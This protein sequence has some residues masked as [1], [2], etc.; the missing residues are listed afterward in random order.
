MR[1]GAVSALAIDAVVVVVFAA[2]G[3]A[4]HGEDLGPAGIAATAWPFLVA[5]LFG[6]LL[7]SRLG[8]DEWW[9]QGLVVWLV[10]AVGGM[11]L[12]VASGTSAA[13]GFIVVGSVFLALFLVGWRFVASR[14]RA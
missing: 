3:R 11:A 14:R 10:T 8:G 1:V 13:P 7:G 12:R 9:R 6:S 4:S 2:I 5:V